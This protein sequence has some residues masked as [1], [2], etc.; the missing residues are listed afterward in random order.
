MELS[1]AAF[2]LIG[3]NFFVWNFRGVPKIALEPITDTDADVLLSWITGPKLCQRWADK[4]LT[5]PLDRQQLLDRFA[6][7]R[8]R[9]VRKIYKAVDVRTGHMVAYVELG[10]I[11][12]SLRRAWLE[13]PLVDTNGSERGRL[14]VKLL[15]AAALHAF[16]E[17]KLVAL[18]VS[19]ETMCGDMAR[20]CDK[21]WFEYFYYYPIV[22]RPHR[23]TSVYCDWKSWNTFR[24]EFNDGSRGQ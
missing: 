11:D 15:R 6:A 13:M 24:A 10:Q 3:D 22:E 8:D 7:V 1:E 17:I 5:W 21:A 4:Q 2:T 14:S 9:T 19:A 23:Q 18:T 20:C 16:R 12:Y